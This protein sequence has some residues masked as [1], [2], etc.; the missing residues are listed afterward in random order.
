MEKFINGYDGFLCTTWVGGKWVRNSGPLAFSFYLY[1]R[2]SLS[3]GPRVKPIFNSGKPKDTF[4]GV[5][6]LCDDWEYTPG[7][8]DST[9]GADQ[10]REMKAFFRKYLVLFCA[11]W[12]LQLDD[13]TVGDYFEG[14]VDFDE[15][16]QSLDFYDEFKRELDQVHDAES[17]EVF[18]RLKNLVNF[19]GN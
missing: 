2:D 14:E 7:P 9:I 18:C 10:I 1:A 3:H 13:P 4:A 8:Q 6:K 12:N 15:V 11:V 19:Y 5:L 17:L 16:I